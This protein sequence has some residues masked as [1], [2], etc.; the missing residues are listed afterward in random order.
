[1]K[2]ISETPF[3]GKARPRFDNANIFQQNPCMKKAVSQRESLSQAQG[4]KK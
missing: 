2:N 3:R 4:E 1:M